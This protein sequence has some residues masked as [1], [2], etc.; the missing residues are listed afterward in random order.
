MERVYNAG[1][2][3]KNSSASAKT[4]PVVDA[5]LSAGTI[6]VLISLFI[7]GLTTQWLCNKA[8]SLFGGYQVGCIIVFNGLFQGLWRG[9]NLEF[10]LSS[11]FWSY[12]LMF[13]VYLLFKSRTILISA[14]EDEQHINQQLL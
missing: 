14:E 9:N 5:Y 1:V 13:L 8:E 12:I 7:Y 4:R 3:S 10:L 2:V 6:G 11:I